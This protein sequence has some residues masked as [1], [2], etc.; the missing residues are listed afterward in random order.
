MFSYPAA[1]TARTARWARSDRAAGLSA[2]VG[3]SS[4]IFWWRRLLGREPFQDLGRRADE[5]EVV[6]AN[7]IREARIL[8]QE[9]VARVDRVAAGHDRGRDHGR[10]RQ[11]AAPRVCRADADRLVRQL[12][13]QTV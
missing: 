9:A 11:V 13:G 2:G 4:M 7:G 5:R 1:T 10:R 3:A 6:R 8:G 12:H